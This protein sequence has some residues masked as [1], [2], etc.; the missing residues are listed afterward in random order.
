GQRD[1]PRVVALE[2]SLDFINLIGIAAV[3]ARVRSLAAHAK[4]RLRELPQV[5]LKTNVEPALSAGVVKFK[6]RNIPTK[7]A[8][9]TLWERH[10]VSI[11]MTPSGDSEGLRISAHIYNSMEQIDR[12]VAAVRTLS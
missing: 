2:S 5:E 4:T 1:D 10:K 9:D 7:R 11:A 6:L 8:Y 12:V 3:E